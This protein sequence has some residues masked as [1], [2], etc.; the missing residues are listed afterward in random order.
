M[1]QNRTRR[2]KTPEQLAN[3]RA[4]RTAAAHARWARCENR[5]EAARPGAEGLDRTLAAKYNIPL[6]APDFAVRIANARKAYMGS[7]AVKSVTARRKA[8][9]AAK[10][11]QRA[12]AELAELAQVADEID[13]EL[14]S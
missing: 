3:M 5:S 8:A 6:D 12:A 10:A 2:E 13:A 4:Q 7:L 9:E 1:T 14:A 11:V